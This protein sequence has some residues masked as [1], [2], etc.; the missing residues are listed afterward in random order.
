[1]VKPY[2][3]ESVL[4]GIAGTDEKT[5]RK[6]AWGIASGLENLGYKLVSEF[7]LSA[8]MCFCYDTNDTAFPSDSIVKRAPG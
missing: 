4:C 6:W 5:F 8:L 1:M 2:A 3:K 7:K